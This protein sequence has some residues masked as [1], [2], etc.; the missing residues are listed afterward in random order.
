[1]S[2]IM[3]RV[4]YLSDSLIY[5]FSLAWKSAFS[6]LA[7]FTCIILDLQ[8]ITHKLQKNKLCNF[9]IKHRGVK[10]CNSLRTKFKEILI[11][12]CF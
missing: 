2:G 9:S 10:I 1:M 12:G 8:K 4:K 5:L 7:L 6:I 3:I 11:K